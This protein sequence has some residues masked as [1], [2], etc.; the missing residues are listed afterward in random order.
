MK[1]DS[2]SVY[3]YMR[4]DTPCTPL[5]RYVVV[6]ILDHLLSSHQLRMYLVDS[7]F[8]NQNY[9][10]A[11][12]SYSLKCKYSR[13]YISKRKSKWYCRMKW[14]FRKAALINNLI[15]QCTKATFVKA[16]SCLVARIVSFDNAGLHLL[17]YRILE[18]YPTKH[19]VLD[20]SHV[21]SH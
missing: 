3:K 19:M 18:P 20:L 11:L 4:R 8:L 16:S 17:T 1:R 12:M 13:K 10:K 9:I 5:P 2:V 15:I 14:T 6:P 21:I 7:H